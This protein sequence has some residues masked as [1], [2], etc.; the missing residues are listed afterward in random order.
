MAGIISI[1]SLDLLT[2]NSDVR[3][4]RFNRVAF[5]VTVTIQKRRDRLTELIFGVPIFLPTGTSMLGLHCRYVTA[6][7]N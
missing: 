2:R 6:N 1:K 7:A 4:N 3:F 5:T